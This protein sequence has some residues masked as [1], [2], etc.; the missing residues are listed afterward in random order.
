MLAIDG[1]NTSKSAIEEVIK[2]IKDQDVHLKII[3]IVDGSL[4]YSGGPTFDYALCLDALRKEG[5]DILKNAAKLIAEKAS[6]KVEKSLLELKPLQKRVS[7]QIIEEAKEWPADL[8]VLG[9]HGRRG[10]SRFF[11]GS[12]AEQVVRMA[13]TPVLLIRSSD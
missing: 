7:E 3:Y 5:H 4:V 6:I 10:F 2:F 13:T 12:V 11:L 1:S 8:L 9:T